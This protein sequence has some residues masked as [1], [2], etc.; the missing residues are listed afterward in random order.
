MGMRSGEIARKTGISIRTLHYYEE[1]G[2]LASVQRTRS[3]HRRYG[4]KEIA[5]LQQ[6]RSLQQIGLSLADIRDTLAGS[7]PLG[8]IQYHLKES[9]KRLDELQELIERLE[10]LCRVMAEE[11]QVT[12]GEL[13]HTIAVMSLTDRH[14]GSP[15]TGE[16]LSRHQEIEA[17]VWSSMVEDLLDEIR[18]GTP[19]ESTHARALT[20]RWRGSIKLLMGDDLM[21]DEDLVAMFRADPQAAHDHGLDEEAVTWLHRALNHHSPAGNTNPEEQR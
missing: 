17:S 4:V 19:P 21:T 16:L 1:V 13:L 3:G 20:R 18:R 14:F 6:I 10:N 15:K 8:V 2:L 9:R 5:R 12:T 11:D 7:E